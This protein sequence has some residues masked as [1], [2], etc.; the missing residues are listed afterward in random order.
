MTEKG[1]YGQRLGE[2]FHLAAAPAFVTR[3]LQKT[4]IAVT[5]I[6]CDAA[7]NGLTAPLPNE[8]AFLVTLQVRDCPEH[9]LWIDDRP[10]QTGPLAAGVT[11][12]YDLR[13]NPIACSISPFHGVHFYLPRSALDAIVEIEGAGQVDDFDNDPGVDD[14]V[15]RG[16][17]WSLLPAFERSE[18][19]N[20]IF[21]DH[22]TMAAAAHVVRVYGNAGLLG[23]V[24]R[25]GLVPAALIRVKELLSANLDGNIALARLAAECGMPTGQFS[26]AF[27]Q[28]TGM[29]PH[30]WLLRRRIDKAKHLLRRPRMPLGE[31]ALA[32]GF[33]SQR[34]FVRVFTCA[35]GA[36]PEAWRRGD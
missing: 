12:I 33:A 28:S 19:A 14:P 20:R 21:V 18:E 29:A 17:G 3:T 26:R 13:R 15:I 9:E 32:C 22:V 11:F 27:E 36:I 16:L 10:V 1:A 23:Q 30:R 31:V 24:E 6:K 35:V 7:N 34:H 5:Q 4:E 2:A 25:G 8:D